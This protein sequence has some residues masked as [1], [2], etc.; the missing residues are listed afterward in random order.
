MLR[1]ICK[2]RLKFVH[3]AVEALMA[4]QATPNPDAKIGAKIQA[5]VPEDAADREFV[6][7]PS[8]DIQEVPE[9]IEDTDLF[10]LA[11]KDGTITVVTSAYNNAETDLTKVPQEALAVEVARRGLKL[12]T[13]NEEPPAP[14]DPSKAFENPTEDQLA[15][16]PEGVLI[17]EF[18]RRGLDT[19]SEAA[20]DKPSDAQLAR[21]PSD[22]LAGEVIKRG[23]VI[24][25]QPQGSSKPA[26]AGKS[27]AGKSG[28]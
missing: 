11:E 5:K 1:I 25:T 12:I 20:F 15:K 18:D 9:W 3:P 14:A 22:L 4:H 17:D 13:G 28:K 19:P 16:I 7:A 27:D 21:I 23:G 24:A 8:P 26:D 2:A 10:D 6:I